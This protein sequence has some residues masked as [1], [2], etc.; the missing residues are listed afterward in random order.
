M[1][2][3]RLLFFLIGLFL[4]LLPIAASSETIR[5][6]CLQSERGAGQ[7]RLCQ[8]LQQVAVGRLSARDQRQ[9]ADFFKDPEE[10]ERVR[11]SDTRRNEAFWDRYETFSESARKICRK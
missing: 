2:A 7:S 6:A 3:L 8:C 5:K 1:P 9:V 4:G 11:R 10:A